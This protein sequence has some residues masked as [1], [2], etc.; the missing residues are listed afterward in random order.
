MSQRSIEAKVGVLILIALGLLAAFIVI[1][2]GLSF[3]PTFRVLID[4]DNPGALQTGAPVKIAGVKIGRVS[5]LQFRGGEIDPTTGEPVPTIRVVTELEAKYNKAIHDD[6]LW[7]IT[8]QGVL[9]EQFLAV[10]PGSHDRPLLQ[11]GAV[12]HGVSPPRLDLLLSESYELLHKAYLSISKHEDKIEETFLGLHATLTGTG[13]FFK[14]NR[15][16]LDTIVTN[17]EAITVEAQDTLKEARE[18]YVSGPQAQR[19]LD[20]LEHSTTTL[21]RDLGP[22]VSDSREVLTDV[23]KLSRALASD[24]QIKRYGQITRDVSTASVQAKQAATG[25]NS[26]VTRVSRGQGTIGALL[27]DEAVYDDLQEMLRDLK[28]NPWKFFWRE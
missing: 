1:M 14:N 6:S 7:Y 12:V 23:K 24:E 27:T 13:N 3:E 26:L 25:A 21:D 20:N 4:F 2:G 8:T 10:E 28:H 11:D 19:I 16:R 22:L 18:R 5:E 9:G 17:T 15:D